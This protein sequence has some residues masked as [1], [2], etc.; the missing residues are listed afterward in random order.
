LNWKTSPEFTTLILIYFLIPGFVAIT[1]LD[2]LWPFGLKKQLADD[3]KRSANP[4]P[5]FYPGLV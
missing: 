2:L 3:H 5:S 1:C 4:L